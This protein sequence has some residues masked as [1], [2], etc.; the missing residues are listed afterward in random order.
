MQFTKK[1]LNQ[2]KDHGRN[3]G[4]YSKDLIEIILK[5]SPKE[6][7][8]YSSRSYYFWLKKERP[9]PLNIILKIIEDKKIKIEEISISGGNKIR[10]PKENAEFF[11]LLGLIL[12]DGC[13]SL[14]RKDSNRS[15]YVLKIACRQ[16]ETA[17]KVQK[18]IERTFECE[19]KIYPAKGC[20]SVDMY[21]KPL[22]LLLNRF[23]DIPIGLKY[24]EIKVPK[25]IKRNN[26]KSIKSF[27]KGMHDSDGNI[28]NHRNNKAVQL[29]QKSERFLLEIRTLFIEIGI[30]F[31][32]PY[33]DKA[34]NSWVLWSSKKEVVDKFI[35]EI[36]GFN[37]YGPVAQLG[38][39]D[40][41]S[42]SGIPLSK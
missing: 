36:I 17:K 13:I 40:N 12:G 23:Y 6:F 2:M 33:K 16:E 15:T 31:N 28:Y 5:H 22:A 14:S 19:A 18:I 42:L 32:K 9:I 34:N 30:E 27:L 21:S 11:Y 37:P 25:I 20:Y 38:N 10:V 26:V 3:I 8:D 4:V 41:I 39:G 1:S 24:K 29:R 35:K 7:S